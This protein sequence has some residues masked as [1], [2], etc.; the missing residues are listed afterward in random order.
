MLDSNGLVSLDTDSLQI[1][2][3]NT[4][5]QSIP[6]D[7]DWIASN[8]MLWFECGIPSNGYELCVS[9]GENA[10]LHSDHVAGM[11]SSNPSK[12]ALVGD[13]VILLIDDPTQGGQ[14]AQITDTGIGVSYTHL[15]A[16]ET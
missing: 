1:T 3:L 10:W 6:Q 4:S 9:D 7:S 16:H 11:E 13:E 8:G 12:F 2:E 15:R 14:L 5:I